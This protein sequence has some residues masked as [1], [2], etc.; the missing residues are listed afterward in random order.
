VRAW[1]SNGGEHLDTLRQNV[2]YGFRVLLKNPGFTAVAV[3]ASALGI[4][5]NTAIFSVVDA[6]LLRSLPY[7]D[8]NRLMTG[9][10]SLPEYQ[11]LEQG[12]QS[13]DRMAVWASN[14]YAATF[15][16][17]AEQ[18]G[19]LIVSPGFF[20]LMGDP[21]MG[22]TFRPDE[23]RQLLAVISYELWRQKFGGAR[24]V[25]GKTLN[26]NGHLHT[27]IGVMPQD[28]NFPNPNYK[29]WVP[30]GSAIKGAPQQAQNRSLRIFSAIGH[31]RPGVK[32]EQAEAEIESFSRR[33]QTQYPASNAGVR[34]SVRPL[35]DALV[36]SASTP[37]LVLFATVGFVLLIACANVANLLL[38][39]TT[40]RRRE[41]ALRAAIGATP[42]RIVAQLLTESVLLAMTGAALGAILA[43]GGVTLLHYL[44]PANLPRLESVAINGRV[45]GFTFLL[46]VLAGILF[47]LMPALQSVKTNLDDSL[48]G[49]GGDS[50][51]G[52]RG[53]RGGLVA[54]EVALSLTVLIGAGL[55][56]ES[57][58][59]L[60]HADSGFVAENLLTMSTN[61]GSIDAAKRSQVLDQIMQRIEHIPGVKRVGA[62]TGL[63]PVTAQRITAFELSDR[64]IT[65]P[66]ARFG[67]LLAPTADYFA[68][69]GTPLLAGR[70]FNDNDTA[71]SPKVI[72]ISK[73]IADKLFPNENPLEKQLKLVNEAQ[74]PEWRTIVGVIGN[75][76]YSG[77]DDK[78]SPAVYTPFAQNPSL[79]GGG[80][81]IMVRTSVSP[82]QVAAG[83]RNAVSQ[84]APDVKAVN[85]HPMDDLIEGS[86]ARPRFDSLMIGI[87]AAVALLLASSGIYAV[88]A[89]SVTQRTREMGIRMALGA[90]RFDILRLVI[91]QGMTFVLAGLGAG[92]LTAL[93][94]TRFIKSM[95][96]EVN[97]FDPV[98]VAS[99]AAM[100]FMVALFACFVPARRATKI[101][102][103]VALRHE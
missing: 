4:G 100:L 61:L 24:D 31:L 72:I 84:V 79:L 99:I 13:Y 2:R 50:G 59:R 45:L 7:R 11:E 56:I 48:R 94:V 55:L 90:Q 1:I 101:D 39:R 73:S 91:G 95:L 28:F 15:D 57:L 30:F 25:L 87:F 49:R 58:E 46:S 26:L 17:D 64:P 60:L 62:S 86:V 44:H 54:L 38:A 65:D 36:G 52:A 83:I 5:A 66:G 42:G 96:Y 34:L 16:G 51:K 80:A 20:P 103:I 33:W 53:L 9:H 8:S 29:L 78:G 71:V 35:Q 19:G 97:P 77:L 74:S 102:P 12:A 14:L 27:I 85:L 10:F 88:I 6:V 23:D 63:P 82:W 22:R 98:V 41:M 32:Q 21:L 69:M 67:Y 93:A 3:L 37:L 89:Y 76:T 18:V 70:F 75:I 43:F 47:G 92:L 68:T 81:Y 40:V